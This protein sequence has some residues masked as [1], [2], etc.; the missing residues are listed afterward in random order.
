MGMDISFRR[1]EFRC[2]ARFWV[3]CLTLAEV[4]GWVP[5]GTEAP[6]GCQPCS[7]DEWD[8]NYW[9]NDYQGVTD[10]DA[11]AF[12]AALKRGIEAVMMEPPLTIEQAQAVKVLEKTE[13]DLVSPGIEIKTTSVA[14]VAQIA[15]LA[16]KGGFMIA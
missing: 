1:G 14:R 12:A 13:T 8:G 6:S 5:A 7:A 11:R 10:D 3:K 16:S 2:S 4:F 9:T 15:A